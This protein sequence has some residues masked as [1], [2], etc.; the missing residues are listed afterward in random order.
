MSR[1]KFVVL[2]LLTWLGH[3]LEGMINR[4]H[5][6]YWLVALAFTAFCVTV[7]RVTD[8]TEPYK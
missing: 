6:T 7:F 4:E 8:A 1:R 3:N 2:L 5:W